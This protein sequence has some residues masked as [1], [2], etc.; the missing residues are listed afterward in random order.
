MR[1][2]PLLAALA[3]AALASS[4][5]AAPVTAIIFRGAAQT[6]DELLQGFNDWDEEKPAIQAAI[7]MG[8][9][10]RPE[11]IASEKLPG[12]RPGYKVLLLGLC[13]ADR[14][15]RMLPLLRTVDPQIYTREVEGVERCPELMDREAKVLGPIQVKAGDQNTLVVTGIAGPF[16]GLAVA[17]LRDPAGKELE[18]KTFAEAC[19]GLELSKLDKARLRVKGTCEVPECTSPWIFER[20]WTIEAEET[21]AVKERTLRTLQKGDCALGR[22][23]N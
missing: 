21:I 10:E 19:A 17:V 6:T 15:A 8:F 1:T 4:A 12:L 11:E 2:S 7:A 23:P 14:A 18:R 3:L 20:S 16:A 22:P 13:P 5:R 9:Q